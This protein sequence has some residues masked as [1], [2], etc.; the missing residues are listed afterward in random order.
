MPY[1]SF[2]RHDNSQNFGDVSSSSQPKTDTCTYIMKVYGK[3]SLKV[4]PDIVNITIGVVTEDKQ[5]QTAQR[6]N[7]EKMKQVIETIK[8][9]G[10]EDNQIQTITYSINPVYDYVDGKEIFRSY[11]VTNI[12]KVNMKNLERVGEIID[13]AVTAGA[14]YVGDIEFTTSDPE[15]YYKRALMI[16]IRDAVEK[17]IVVGETLGVSVYKIPVSIK[18][19]TQGFALVMQKVQVASLQASTP[20]EAGE[21]EITAS[22]EAEFAYK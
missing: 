17:A 4:M 7:A 14:N 12:V 3:G 8:S 19:Q 18:E 11:R 21:L 16:A 20:I 10:I 9:F 13:S 22:V 2:Y 6:T 1:N 5:L 15:K